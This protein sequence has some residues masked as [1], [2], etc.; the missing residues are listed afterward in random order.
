LLDL[1][2]G[3]SW[4]T[5]MTKTVEKRVRSVLGSEDDD[6]DEDADT[7]NDDDDEDDGESSAE[8]DDDDEGAQ[9]REKPAPS[10]NKKTAKRGAKKTKSKPPSKK[11]IKDKKKKESRSSEKKKRKT[12]GK[13][14]KDKVSVL[15]SVDEVPSEKMTDISQGEAS[16]TQPV[17]M[18]MTAMEVEQPTES[19]IP[20]TVPPTAVQPD[21][22]VP[23]VTP[24]KTPAVVAPM[25]PLR[26]PLAP[27]LTKPTPR[28]FS[29]AAQVAASLANVGSQTQGTKPPLMPRSLTATLTD[30]ATTPLPAATAPRHGA[31]TP[32]TTSAPTPSQLLSVPPA[33]YTHPTAST[34]TPA[35]AS[36]PPVSTPTPAV[37]KDLPPTSGKG[38]TSVKP[39]QQ[40]SDKHTEKPS[41][42][43]KPNS[44]K[45][46][47]RSENPDL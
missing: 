11:N 33:T 37:L 38:K 5:Y 39:T 8:D 16:D 25:I 30:S 17:D 13:Y 7:K 22:I 32:T 42:K 12:A 45:R 21:Q 28:S 6:D 24:L 2:G 9:K 1:F 46:A 18:E 15:T 27:N 36:V 41:D 31:S 47:T 35:P 20:G 34:P 4:E 26:S 44:Q 14:E 19:V 3:T 29:E 23:V 10:T 40:P 43:A